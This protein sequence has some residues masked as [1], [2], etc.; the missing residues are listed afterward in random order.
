MISVE[1]QGKLGVKI[2]SRLFGVP[3]R[4][5]QYWIKT[6][7]II[8]Q[9][10]R[11]GHGHPTILSSEDLLRIAVITEL[12]SRGCSMQRIRKTYECLNDKSNTI[13]L[14]GKCGQVFSVDLKRMKQKLNQQLRDKERGLCL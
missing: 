7:L 2:A 3:I 8:P 4:T 14:I 9:E 11:K 12:R 10:Y 6:A 13:S 5:L 1:Q